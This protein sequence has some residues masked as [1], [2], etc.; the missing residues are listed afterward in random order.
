MR[1]HWK[2]CKIEDV[3]LIIL[4]VQE[5]VDDWLKETM[6]NSAVKEEEDEE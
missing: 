1:D 3:E 6:N 2:N 4:C 5:E